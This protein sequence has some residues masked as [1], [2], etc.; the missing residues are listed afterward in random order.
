MM[1]LYVPLL[2]IESK[3]D[4]NNI[5]ENADITFNKTEIIKLMNEDGFGSFDW[6][7]LQGNLNRIVAG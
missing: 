3:K 1:Q 5:L 2:T 6:F 4:I 7:E